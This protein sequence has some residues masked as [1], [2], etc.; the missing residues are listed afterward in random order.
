VKLDASFCFLVRT[1]PARIGNNLLEIRQRIFL[2]TPAPPIRRTVI[3]EV[4]LTSTRSTPST[5]A[6]NPT[7]RS[8]RSPSARSSFYPGPVVRKGA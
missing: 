3:G 7:T 5:L 2:P 8:T 1:L 4:S 6:M